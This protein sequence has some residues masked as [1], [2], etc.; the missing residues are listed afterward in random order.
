MK[1][2]ADKDHMKNDIKNHINKNSD[3]GNGT[4]KTF[5]N[6]T[7]VLVGAAP[8][9]EER[10]FLEHI[11]SERER[12]KEDG[13]PIIIA[14]DGG[15]DFF[16][17]KDMLPDYWVGDMDSV[18]ETPNGTNC[19]PD[20]RN[21]KGG[22]ETDECNETCEDNGTGDGS[23]TDGKN[24]KDGIAKAM[25]HE[26]II[27]VP[28]EKDDTD[29]ELAVAK[30]YE[31][32]CEEILIFGGM[33]GDRVSHTIANIQLM[34]RYEK[35]GCHIRMI[36]ERIQAEVLYRG[37]KAFSKE[38][39]GFLSV[40]SLSDEAKD[41][42]IEGMKY[43]YCGNLTNDKPLG[44]SNAFIGRESRVSVG[45]G[46]LLL[47]YE[48][49]KME[50]VV[51][52]MDGVIF[53]SENLVIECWQVVAEKYKIPDIEAA[54]HECLGIN[55]AL[56][57]ELM[58]RRYGQ[59]FPYDAYKKE[60]SALFHE[61]AAGGKLPQKPG[62]KELLEYLKRNRVKIALASSTRREVVLRELEEGG[63]LHYFDQV[64]CGDMVSRSKPEPDIFLK[65][66]ESLGVNP[67]NAFAVEDSY[68][69]IRSAYRAG[70][71]P[72]MVPDLSEPTP[73]M[74]ELA[75]RIFPSLTEVKSHFEKEKYFS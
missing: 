51:F 70:M 49:E 55:A 6:E 53:D 10:I 67:A 48:K 12:G 17:S 29:M 24:D 21:D 57:K 13:R 47:I 63:L 19:N 40:L 11:L 60:M 34:L 20:G 15:M 14:V 64:I 8:L 22:S 58:L 30:A 7:G 23:E 27:R 33:G 16:R 61:R 50:A 75:F 45:E 36:S 26:R 73:E 4:K 69:G 41:V 38:M 1:N 44:V 25:P 56:T 62:V 43:E 3:G 68:N 9:G 59:D 52:D 31:R 18:R 71:K 54:C 5:G 46:A 74:E 37:V 32:G 39:N 66:C 35:L 72:V 2:Y 65:A 42:K 28:V